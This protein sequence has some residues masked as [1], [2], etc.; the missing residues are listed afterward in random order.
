MRFGRVHGKS[1]SQGLRAGMTL[2]ELLVV[3]AIITL[4]LGLLIPGVQS[5]RESARMLQCRNNLR[6]LGQGLA[7]YEHA[8]KRFPPATEWSGSSSGFTNPWTRPNWVALILA[9]IEQQAVFDSLDST[10]SIAAESN[11]RFRGTSLPVMLCPSDFSNATPFNGTRYHGMSDGWG[12]GNYAATGSQVTMGSSTAWSNKAFRGMMGMGNAVTPDMVTDGMS[13]TIMIC[14][15]RVGLQEIDPRGTWAM[16]DSAS[17]VWGAGSFHWNE[18]GPWPGADCNGPNPA[19]M[20]RMDQDNIVSCRDIFNSPRRDE[21][22]QRELMG[23]WPDMN[24]SYNSQSAVRSR[25]RGGVFVCL[26][27]GSVQWISDYIDTNGRIG[28]NPPLFSVWDRL[29][30]SADGQVIP[31]GAF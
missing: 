3:I 26:A 30:A 5:A 20:F 10:Q 23:C 17:S 27:D 28:R 13:N 16:G 22:F 14:E 1:G 4:L 19:N 11:R 18:G 12:R 15:I 9:R 21:Y 6:Q 8:F 25:H 29:M 31:D 2:V 7:N 24:G